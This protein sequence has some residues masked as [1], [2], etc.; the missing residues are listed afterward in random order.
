[1]DGGRAMQDG[2]VLS[3]PGCPWIRAGGLLI[4]KGN[5]LF[6]A[7]EEGVG[8]VAIGWGSLP[9][10]PVCLRPIHGAFLF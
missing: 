4:P 6:P 10:L 1:M 8:K 7:L 9:R 3:P 5:E 2:S